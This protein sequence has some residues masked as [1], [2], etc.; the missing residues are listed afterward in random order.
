MKKLLIAL[1][2][3]LALTGC[4]TTSQYLE[5][6]VTC[7]VAKDEARADSK[8]GLFGISTKIAEADSKAICK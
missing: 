6:R 3:G 5:T 7:T 4:G 2:L 8:W 1:C